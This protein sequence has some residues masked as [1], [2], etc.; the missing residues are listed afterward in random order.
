MTVFDKS[1]K[2]NRRRLNPAYVKAVTTAVNTN[3]YFRLISMEIT[4]MD[5]ARCRMEVAV[6]DKH[7]QNFGIVHGGV[8]SSLVDAAAFWAVYLQ[9]D[10]H[11]GMTT[12]EIKVNYLAPASR[13]YLIAK[14]KSIKVGNTLC[15]GEALIEDETGKLL[16]HGTATMMVLSDLKINAGLI[17]PPKFLE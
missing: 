7:L 5:C 16:A 8:Y 6:Q 1:M 15:L 4:D 3:P 13:G 9:I 10:E 12:T 2:T 11:L 17:L 14:G